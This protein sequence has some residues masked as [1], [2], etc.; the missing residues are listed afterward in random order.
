MTRT[1][2]VACLACLLGV[3]APASARQ[4][5][6]AETARFQLGPLALAPAIRITNFGFDTNVF[7]EADDPTSDLTAVFSPAVDGWLRLGRVRVSG[8]SELDFV[9]FNELAAQRSVDSDHDVRVELHASRLRPYAAGRFTNTRHRR[10]VEIDALARRREEVAAIGLDF[11]LSGKTTIG[12]VTSRFRTEYERDAVFLESRLARVLN[13]SATA[14]GASVR[15]A[16]TPL[17]TIVV[18]GERRRDRFDRAP[19]RDA[20]SIRFTPGLDFK[21][22]ALVSGR[23]RIGFRRHRFLDPRIPEFRG[24]VASIELHYTLLGATRFTVQADRDLSYSYRVQEADYLQT[25][26][27]G[28]VTRRLPG[29][30]DVTATAGRHH[31][32]YRALGAT[33]PGGIG[34]DSPTESVVRYGGGFGF[35]AGSGS[36][37]GVQ[38]ERRQRH[39][40]LSTRREYERLRVTTSLTHAF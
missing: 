11:R 31:L 30:W 26:I 36:R 23:A 1:R 5:D 25:G 22:F 24:A 10:N 33:G 29:R 32:L 12:V 18:E 34:A 2:L 20:D 13:R 28:S 8:R 35:R 27:T 21:P 17:T 39:S 3:A 9:Y 40:D 7:N 6:G 19:E 38:V 14:E 4:P 15:Y 16:V 37:L